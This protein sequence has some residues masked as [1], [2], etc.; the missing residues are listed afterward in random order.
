[1]I[2]GAHTVVQDIRDFTSHGAHIIITTPGRFM[3]LLI[4]QGDNINLAGGL[5][6]LVS[7]LHIH[8]S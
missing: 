6:S 7:L 1:M 2:G 4:R 3:D 5:K 8:V